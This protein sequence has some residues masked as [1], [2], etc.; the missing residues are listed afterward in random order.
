MS[1]LLTNIVN[2]NDL[3]GR[4][5]I[6]NLETDDVEFY[7]FIRYG[8]IMAGSSF[9]QSKMSEGTLELVFK[10]EDLYF[11]LLNK[12]QTSPVL[13]EV[14]IHDDYDN[15]TADQYNKFYFFDILSY[16]DNIADNSKERKL[17]FGLFSTTIEKN[18]IGE[19]TAQYDF[20]DL[21]VDPDSG[22]KI[23]PSDYNKININY[24][25][26]F[27]VFNLLSYAVF[28]PSDRNKGDFHV[29]D[30]DRRMR[31][32]GT[33]TAVDSFGEGQ[34]IVRLLE[35]KQSIFSLREK[36]NNFTYENGENRTQM[37]EIKYNL[38]TLKLD[39]YLIINETIEIEKQDTRDNYT[40]FHKEIDFKE[41]VV[42]VLVESGGADDKFVRK[43]KPCPPNLWKA[44]ES[45]E[46][47]TVD[48]DGG[49][50]AMNGSADA[51]M[52]GKDP[53]DTTELDI[54]FTTREYFKT[55]H[56]GQLIT[57][58]GFGVMVDGVYRVDQISCVVEQT[59]LSYAIDK[60]T[61]L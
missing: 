25:I 6:A 10:D 26:D 32:L 54:D 9:N 50:D 59:Y 13:I 44:Y 52:T 56:A 36:A 33:L 30:N 28:H 43:K 18:T 31:G 35:P 61:K 42:D 15:L 5:L 48:E 41:D 40:F 20:A 11:D 16:T 46:S 19:H 29:A 8:D 39:F 23:I 24:E 34:A 17:T 7:K 12:V 57:L 22:Q 60:M 4:V 49:L 27:I 37:I 51:T 45:I 38:A 3:F 55:L 1:R 47:G 2:H 21:P 14:F 53:I 58:S